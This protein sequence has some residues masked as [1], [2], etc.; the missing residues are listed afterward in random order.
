MKA[1][2]QKPYPHFTYFIEALVSFKKHE[3]DPADFPEWIKSLERVIR[4]SKPG[5]NKNFE[6]YCQFSELFFKDKTIYATKTKRWYV[7]AD[8]YSFEYDSSE[9]RV[10]FKQGKLIGAS[11][12][13]TIELYDLNTSYYPVS[14][15]VRGFSGRISWEKNGCSKERN[16]C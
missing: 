15:I 13:D 5:E 14:Y 4:E 2:R 3:Q 1:N 11:L 16:A 7:E 6:R 8:D 9:V 12:K 10:N